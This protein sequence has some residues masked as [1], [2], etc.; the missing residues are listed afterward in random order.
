MS[1]KNNIHHICFQRRRW[2]T[3]YARPIRNAFTRKVPVGLH[4]ELHSLLSTVPVPD[5]Q[6]L[7]IA[8]EEYQRNKDEIDGYGVARAAAWLYTHIPDKEFRRAMQIQIDF[9]TENLP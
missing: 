8:W 6:L 9:F 2:N 1:K 3:G 7:R 4:D 5:G